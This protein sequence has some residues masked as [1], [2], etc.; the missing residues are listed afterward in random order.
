[1]RGRILGVTRLNKKAAL[2]IIGILAVL[3]AIVVYSVL[4]R[5]K[6]APEASIAAPSPKADIHSTNVTERVAWYASEPDAVPALQPS[7]HKP[8]RAGAPVPDLSEP[9]RHSVPN[10][11]HPAV[12][13]EKQSYNAPASP[14]EEAQ[15]R[16]E[17]RQLQ[18]QEQA[19]IAPLAVNGFQA[20]NAQTQDSNGAGQSTPASMNIPGVA[21]FASALL[22]KAE[23]PDPNQ[24]TGK[25]TFLREAAKTAVEETNY[26]PALRQPPLTPYELKAGTVIPAVL[27]SGINSDLPGQITAQV[28]ENVY[29]TVSGRHV[30]IPQ[31]SRL[32]G[33]YDSQVTYGQ[34]RVLIAWQRLLFPDGSSLNLQ[35]MPG[36]DAGGYSGFN[37][38]VNNHYGQIFGS[39]I[40][41]SI[42]GAGAQLSQPQQGSREGGAPDASQ[43]IA[44]QLGQQMSEAGRELVRKGLNIQ[45]TLEIRPGYVFNVMVVKDVVIDRPYVDR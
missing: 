18:A 5:G 13:Y 14:V 6:R 12:G 38:R 35:G 32:I 15:R 28:R 16:R 37:D 41:M 11:Q 1:M 9:S 45:P 17:E 23:S 44:G 8:A 36:T 39:A 25:E 30:I 33:V 21:E 24:Q 29:D 2:V 31:G 26:L 42:L 27:I 4:Q 40:L 22:N 34:R 43:I 3:A 19:V 10:L 20:P 7:L